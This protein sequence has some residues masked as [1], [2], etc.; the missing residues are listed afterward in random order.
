MLRLHHG[1]RVYSHLN[2]KLL[3]QQVG[4][5]RIKRKIGRLAYKLELPARMRIHPIVSLSQLEPILRG[6]DPYYRARNTKPLL[7]EHE[8]DEAPSYKIEAL[9]DRKLVHIRGRLVL[10]YLVKWFGYGPAYNKWYDLEDLKG[11]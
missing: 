7:V 1:Y 5:F 3:N 4:P 9:L 8:D 6:K 2:R 11:A 10:R